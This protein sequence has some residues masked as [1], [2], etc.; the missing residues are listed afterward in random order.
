MKDKY[1]RLVSFVIVIIAK[2]AG[3]KKV[4]V[5]LGTDGVISGVTVSD[6]MAYMDVVN[7]LKN[8]EEVELLK[9]AVTLNIGVN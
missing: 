5:R 9:L 4:S 8:M 2:M 7:L 1:R 3:I 6:D